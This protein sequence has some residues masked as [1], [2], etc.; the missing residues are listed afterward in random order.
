VTCANIF[1]EVISDT[2]NVAVSFVGDGPLVDLEYRFTFAAAAADISFFDSNGATYAPSLAGVAIAVAGSNGV[3]TSAGYPQSS[4]F[5]A[6]KVRFAFGKAATQTVGDKATVKVHV[7]PVIK[8]F[9][10]TYALAGAV[11]E[12]TITSAASGTYRLKYK[13]VLTDYISYSVTAT[14]VTN[15]NTAAI[16]QALNALSTIYPGF[17]K[18]TT[19]SGTF[20]VTLFWS[21]TGLSLL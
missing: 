11:Q 1:Q 19:D 10:P 6:S 9:N 12:F 21:V 8:A 15:V 7:T 5:E 18:V 13:D 16:E 3:L 17:V 20:F 14:G 2:Q 4:H